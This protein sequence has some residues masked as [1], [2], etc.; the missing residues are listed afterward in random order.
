MHRR[1]CLETMSAWRRVDGTD[2]VGANLVADNPRYPVRQ[3]AG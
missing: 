1:A 3:P 2:I